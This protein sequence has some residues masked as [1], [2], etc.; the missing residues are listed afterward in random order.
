MFADFGADVL[1]VEAPDG[2]PLRREPPFDANGQGIA[3]SLFL[4]NK[5]SVVLDLQAAAGR[6]SLLDLG[7][8][9]DVIVSSL[10]P[11]ALA[12]LGLNYTGFAND[13]LILCHITPFGMS[14]ARAEDPGNELT[15][16]ALSG[17]ASLNGDADRYPLKPA[18]HQVGLCAGTAAYGVIVAA[19][20]ARDRSGIGGQ[21]IDVAELDV[22]VSA[23]SPAILRGQYLGSPASRRQ[24]VDITTGP[25]P[26]ADGY[27]ALTISRAHFW[28]DAMTVLGLL[29]LAE[30]P[31]WEAAW[32]R[33]AHKDEYTG[34]VG[35]AMATW[36][37]AELFEELAAR[38]VIAG[39]VL[40]MEDLRTNEH[41]DDRDFWTTLGDD[42]YPGPPFR[43]S[44][45]P[46]SL[47]H[48]APG[49]GSDR[50]GWAE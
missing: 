8:D 5:R 39:P 44:E 42:I 38:R 36:K 35:A 40:T 27:F 28:R 7:R 49:S 16:A 21:E 22:M 4:A 41:L 14:G 29:D 1:L 45:T 6:D 19:L 23:A 13:R 26:V 33:A 10:R 20:V 34:R 25:V 12:A 2:H 11:A 9:A 30:D 37:K 50:A 18:G 43:M 46:W 48:P 32:Y 47:Q 15:V 17:W 3:A 31:R 24:S